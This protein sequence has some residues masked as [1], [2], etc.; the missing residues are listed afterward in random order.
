MGETAF[1]IDPWD[2]D[3]R[4]RDLVLDRDPLIEVVRAAVAGRGNC[5]DNNP[6]SS[7]G[8]YAWDFAITELRRLYRGKDGWDRFEENGVEGIVHHKRKLKIT[9]VS[10]DF[11]TCDKLRSPRNRTPKGPATEKITDLNSQ[12]ELFP[13]SDIRRSEDGYQMYVICIFDD[14]AKV[15]A[16]LSLPVRFLSNHFIKF[17]ER[18]FLIGPDEWEK[19]SVRK[20]HEGP[21]GSDIEIKVR[22]K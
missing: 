20:D 15:R 13:R 6:K 21:S 12:Y 4:L 7:P 22:R 9:V 16:E 14:G 17:S 5:T 3:K 1:Y 11:G 8:F 10:T 18:I 19:L 2:R